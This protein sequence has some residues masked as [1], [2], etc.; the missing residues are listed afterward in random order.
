MKRENPR[1]R[2]PRLRYG[3]PANMNT[4]QPL[5]EDNIVYLQQGVALLQRLDNAAYVR[6][7][8]ATRSSGFGP[9]LRH[10]LDH[11]DRFLAG[12]PA[13]RVDY[14]ARDRDPRTET[15]RAFALE[16]I[17]AIIAALEKISDAHADQPLEIK[18]DSG[19]E[20]G[21]ANWWSKSTVHRELQFLVSHTVHHYALIAF[22]LRA[23][24]LDIGPE[25]GVAPSTL[26]HQKSCVR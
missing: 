6:G 24:G 5:A 7:N 9:H 15:D 11:Y 16:K 19:S 21:T 2:A 18:M 25:F 12:L 1:C 20:N 22:I 3:S 4:C 17:R 10:C 14:D 26:R 13:G 8:P 23:N